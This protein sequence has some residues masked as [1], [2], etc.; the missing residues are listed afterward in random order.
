MT[1]VDVYFGKDTEMFI[2]ALE[3]IENLNYI[4]GLYHVTYMR[5]RQLASE[6]YSNALFEKIIKE[7]HYQYI[8]IVT[9]NMKVK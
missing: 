7:I 1:S 9:L 2:R 3:L 8:S 5:E 4:E 6:Y